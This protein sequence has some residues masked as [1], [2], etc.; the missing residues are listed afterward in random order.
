MAPVVEVL[1]ALGRVAAV[2]LPGHG[3]TPLPTDAPFSID[4]FSAT[5]AVAA[6]LHGDPPPVVFGHSMGGYVALALEAHAPGTFA[7]IVTLGTKFEWTPESAAREVQRLDPAVMGAKVPRFAQA[8]KARHAGAGGWELVVQRTASLLTAIGA[9]PVLTDEMLARVQVP[10]RLAVGTEDDTVGAH[11]TAR[12]AARMPNAEMVLLDATPHA[13]E[14]VP[15]E[16]L[17]EL[18]GSLLAG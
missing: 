4:S 6:R 15:L 1:R 16:P 17:V 12:T 18:V 13:I 2:E 5:L 10:V 14:R 3:A 8:L 7:G 9:S 11:E